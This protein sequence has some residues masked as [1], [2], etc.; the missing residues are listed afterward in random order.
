MKV[1]FVSEYS[2]GFAT[3]VQAIEG[4]T[5]DQLVRDHLKIDSCSGHKVRVNNN[6]VEA[7]YEVVE[8]DVITVDSV[9][10]PVFCN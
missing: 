4:I 3:P 6:V 8:N 5:I 7:T 9:V 2:G 1:L 10:K